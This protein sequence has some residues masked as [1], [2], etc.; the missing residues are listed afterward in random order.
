MYESDT[1]APDTTE[2]PL[3]RK[4]DRVESPQQ[5]ETW[6]DYAFSDGSECD[7]GRRA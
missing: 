1:R 3:A 6:R 4:S 2:I 7:R 5:Y